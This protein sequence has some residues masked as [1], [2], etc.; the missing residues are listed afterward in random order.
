MLG[1]IEGSGGYLYPFLYGASNGNT[2]GKLKTFSNGYFDGGAVIKNKKLYLLQ[3][4]IVADTVHY[5]NGK[6]YTQRGTGADDR[7]VASG[8]NKF[9]YLSKKNGKTISSIPSNGI[10]LKVEDKLAIVRKYTSDSSAYV[11]HILYFTQHP[12]LGK[13]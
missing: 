3:N 4:S 5:Q 2:V 1:T 6:Y 8:A 12:I 9:I 11:Y 13:S 10:Y 7:V